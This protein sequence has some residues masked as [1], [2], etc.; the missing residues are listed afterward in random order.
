MH[1]EFDIAYTLPLME[2]CAY[3][4][5]GCCEPLDNK[6]DL[7]RRIPNLRKVGC[8]PWANPEKMAEAME[9][10]YVLARKPNPALVAGELDEAAIREETERTV[11]AAIRY[12][13]PCELVLKDISTVGYRPDNLTR[14]SGVVSGVLDRY[15]T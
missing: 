13:C 4:Y 14:W 1:W 3:T 15:Y 7:L 2:Q 11:K 10:R 8:S 6:L 9:G 12:G 5:Y